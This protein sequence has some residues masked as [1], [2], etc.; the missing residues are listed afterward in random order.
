MS[1]DCHKEKI[2]LAFITVYLYSLWR[3]HDENIDR[4]SEGLGGC[5][6]G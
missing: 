3:R 2:N 1:A 4:D 5:R 6:D